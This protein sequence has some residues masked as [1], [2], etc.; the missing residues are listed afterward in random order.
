MANVLVCDI[1]VRENEFISLLISLSG[2][3]PS[4]RYGLPSPPDNNIT[5]V[6]WMDGFDIKYP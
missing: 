3:H 2:Y 4:E 1:V 6:L 5:T